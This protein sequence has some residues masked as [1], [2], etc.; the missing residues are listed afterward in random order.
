MAEKSSPL[1]ITSAPG[2]V[3]LFGE[4]AVVYEGKKAIASTISQ[5]TFLMVQP[6]DKRY[7]V[8]VDL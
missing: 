4:H 6:Y 2:K 1:V 5:R 3:I 7:V 8:G